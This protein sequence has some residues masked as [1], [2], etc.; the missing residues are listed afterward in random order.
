MLSSD[1]HYDFSVPEKEFGGTCR[2]RSKQCDSQRRQATR[3]Q[4]LRRNSFKVR[5]GHNAFADSFP[6]DLDSKRA[7]KSTEQGL[8]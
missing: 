3:E 7:A 1:H 8:D 2:G 5:R 6:D 4:R